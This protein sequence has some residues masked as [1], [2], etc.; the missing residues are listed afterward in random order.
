M[1]FLPYIFFGHR[2]MLWY[3]ELMLSGP[4]DLTKTIIIPHSRLTETFMNPPFLY[5][6]GEQMAS[7]QGEKEM[8]NGQK[9][10]AEGRYDRALKAFQKAMK[11]SPEVADTFFNYAEAAQLVQETETERIVEAYKKA[12]E[13]DP[14]NAYYYSSYGAFCNSVGRF[15]EAEEMYKKA[16][17]LDPENAP[18]YFSEFA[19]DYSTNAPIVM[20]SIL[21]RDPSAMKV[22]KKK[23]LKY[24]LIALRIEPEEVP[25]LIK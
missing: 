21:S 12:I 19:V 15:N 20:E 7:E 17:E 4:Q 1:S 5:I 23:A 10:L 22:I 2:Q 3:P 16:A 18:L 14:K 6:S 24:A 25:E 8:I 13:L 9:Y 11:L